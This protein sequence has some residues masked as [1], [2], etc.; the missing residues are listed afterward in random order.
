M[1]NKVNKA[2]LIHK[3]NIYQM[4]IQKRNWKNTIKRTSDKNRIR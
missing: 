1:L 3:K 4:E 2:I